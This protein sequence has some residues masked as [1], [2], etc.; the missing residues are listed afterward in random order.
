MTD[1]PRGWAHT[2]LREICAINPRIDKSAIDPRHVVSFVPMPAVE[3]GNGKI[4]VSETRS[5]ETVRKGYTPFRKGDVLF[6]KITP[7][8]E[9]GKMAVVPDLASE[10]G[11][12]STEFHV[13]RPADGIDPRFIYHAVSNQ[14]FRFHAEHNMTG[15]VGQKR[16]PAAIIEQHEIVL[17]PSNE[18]RR[19]V[20]RVEALFDEIERGVESLRTA[21]RMIGLYRQSLLKSAFEGRLTADWRAENADKLESPEL[22]LARISQQ[23]EA[24]YDAVIQDWQRALAKWRGAGGTAKR[25]TKPKPPRAMPAEQP[26][27][28]VPGWVTVPLGLVVD[29]PIYGTPKKCGYGT[30]AMGVLRIPN[31]GSGCIDPTDLKSADFDE[32]EVARFSLSEGDVLTVR[33][34]GSLSIVGKPAL[35]RREHADYLFAGYLIRLRPVAQSLL[36]KYLVYTLMEPQV[37]A[38]IETKAKSTSGVNNVSAKELQE[39]GIRICSIAEQSEIVRILDGRLEV[40]DTLQAE[41]DANLARSEALRQSILRTALAGQLVPQ[42]PADQPASALLARVRAEHISARK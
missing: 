6:A 3:A 26:Q 39:L 41:V 22:L 12:G 24:C 7:C 32:S 21:R 23:R 19:I 30:G 15:A 4:D 8:M 40:A 11:F 33:S 29:D 16:V 38:Q 28:D 1:C 27:H 2:T 42:D 14:A 34:N 18:Q 36:P 25:P 35:V 5:F 37:R 13:L 31:I 10:Y 9:N 20:E 17:P